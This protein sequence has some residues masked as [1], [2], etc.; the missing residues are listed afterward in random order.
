MKE[1]RK[2]IVTAVN[3]QGRKDVTELLQ[4]YACQEDDVTEVLQS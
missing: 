1:R 2:R 3:V 4:S